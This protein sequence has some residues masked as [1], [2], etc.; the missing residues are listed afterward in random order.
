MLSMIRYL[1]MSDLEVGEA[2]KKSKL[3]KG[4]ATSETLS[5]ALA[6]FRARLSQYT[7]S[8]EVRTQPL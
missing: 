2:M 4:S 7:T 5:K 3:P 1:T 8:A 6:V